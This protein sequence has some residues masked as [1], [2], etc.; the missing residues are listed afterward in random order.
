MTIFL[1]DMKA[2]YASLKSPE[3]TSPSHVISYRPSEKTKKAILI[4]QDLFSKDFS[5]LFHPGRSIEMKDTLGYLSTVAQE[6]G[7]NCD[8]LT[9]GGLKQRVCMKHLSIS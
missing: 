8:G 7:L 3:E 9:R 4:L 1:T 5:L 2:F 6:E